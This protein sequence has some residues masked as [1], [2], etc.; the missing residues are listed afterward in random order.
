[1]TDVGQAIRAHF[2]IPAL[3]GFVHRPEFWWK[4][5]RNEHKGDTTPPKDLLFLSICYSY[6]TLVADGGF[7]LRPLLDMA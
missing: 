3:A 4:K 7:P 1:M 6:W 2:R 5:T